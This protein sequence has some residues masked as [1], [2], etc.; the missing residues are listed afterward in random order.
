MNVGRAQLGGMGGGNQGQQG[1]RRQNGA[2]QGGAQH[3]YLRLEYGV[4]SRAG[5]AS[6]LFD[7]YGPA[8]YLAWGAQARAPS[9]C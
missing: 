4:W 2:G 8:Y 6:K 9:G 7:R 1:S 3:V 5:T